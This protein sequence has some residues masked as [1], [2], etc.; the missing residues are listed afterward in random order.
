VEQRWPTGQLAGLYAQHALDHLMRDAIRC[1][2][3]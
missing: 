3:M 1:D 2:Q